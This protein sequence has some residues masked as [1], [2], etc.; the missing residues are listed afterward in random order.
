MH[1]IYYVREGRVERMQIKAESPAKATGAFFQSF[2]GLT[3]LCNESLLGR[4]RAER[5]AKSY[6]E[7]FL[8]KKGRNG[9]NH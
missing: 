2:C 3:Y 8:K 7:R 4:E 9:E 5:M 1:T 6:E